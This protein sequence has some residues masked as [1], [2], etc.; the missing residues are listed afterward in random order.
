MDVK[1]RVFWYGLTLT[2][3]KT[4]RSERDVLDAIEITGAIAVC[5]SGVRHRRLDEFSAIDDRLCRLGV[6]LVAGV[7]ADLV[8]GLESPEMVAPGIG[9]DTALRALIIKKRYHLSYECYVPHSERGNPGCRPGFSAVFSRWF[10]AG[11][12]I[13][14]CSV[15]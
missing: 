12:L 4:S 7:H 6:E 5:L 10:H 15:T 11:N 8:V 9:A 13:R 3:T 14:G 1:S 2:A